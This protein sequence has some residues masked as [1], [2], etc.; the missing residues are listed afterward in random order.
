M[1]TA[2]AKESFVSKLD[3]YSTLWLTLYGEARGEPIEGQIG[4]GFVIYNRKF[5]RGLSPKAVCLQPAQFSCWNSADPNLQVIMSAFLAPSAIERKII[6]Q[7]RLVAKGI[8]TGDII[9]NTNGSNH[10][11]ST[12]LYRSPQ[13]PN[14]AKDKAASPKVV[15]GGHT[16]I[17]CP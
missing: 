6:A 17:W 12:K 9:D 5:E 15:L 14:W 1:V 7:I 8:M 4:V 16:F 2:E 10:Y 13:C 3:D 11:L